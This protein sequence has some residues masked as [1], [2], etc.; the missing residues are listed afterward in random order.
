LSEA[1]ALAKTRLV[2][3]VIRFVAIISGDEPVCRWAREKIIHR[4]GDIAEISPPQAFEAGGYYAKEMGEGLSKTLVALREPC[5]PV[6]LALWKSQTNDWEQE[7]A[8]E[9]PGQSVR[10]LNLDPGYITQA[11]LVLA[12]IKDRDHRIYLR[13]GIFAEIT[14]SYVGGH[15]VGHRWTYPDYRT[16]TVF[17]F[18]TQ[19]R[20]RLRQHLRSI[21]AFRT[22]KKHSF[23]NLDR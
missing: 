1:L 4:W 3:P 18:A 20:E 22:G 7:A 2:E 14:L 23:L 6:D 19:C 9:F 21:G 11:K 5:D 16:D 15:W 13:D 17:E 10:P 12:T 8:A